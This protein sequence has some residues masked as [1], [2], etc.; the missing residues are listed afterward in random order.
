MDIINYIK[1]KHHNCRIQASGYLVWVYCG[2][3]KPI[4]YDINLLNY[5]IETK[6]EKET[7]TFK[8]KENN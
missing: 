5:L 6:Q 4:V 2:N 7:Q 8:E 1:E 3:D